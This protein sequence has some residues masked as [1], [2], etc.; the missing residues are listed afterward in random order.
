LSPQFPSRSEINDAPVPYQNLGHEFWA[1]AQGFALCFFRFTRSVLPQAGQYLCGL[2]QARRAT[3]LQMADVVP[4]SDSQALHHFLS[5]SDWDS[6]RVMDQV[7]TGVDAELG[8]TLDSCLVIDESSFPKK[9]NKSVGVARQWCGT[10]GK[11]DSCQVG[12]FASLGHGNRA[13]LIDAR[14]YLP[15]E[16]T[17]SPNRCRKAG[18]P[19]SARTFQTKPELALEMVHRARAQGLR[20]RWVAA[21]GGYG[22]NPAF[23][24]ALDDAGEVFVIDIHRD[25]RI[26]A[27]DPKPEIPTSSPG[28]SRRRVTEKKPMRVDAWLAQQ[29]ES[30]WQREWIRHTTKGELHL[31]VMRDMVWLWNGREASARCWHLLVTRDPNDPESLKYS[32]SN[33]SAETPAGRLAQIQ[34]QRYWIERAFQDAKREAGMA[35]YQARSWKAWHHHMALVMMALLFLLQQRKKHQST[36][37]LLSCTD[38]KILLAKVLPRRDVGLDEVLRLMEQRHK[39]RQAATKSAYQKRR[40]RDGPFL[41]VGNLTK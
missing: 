41:G 37:P 8:G 25:Q 29:P 17:N 13:S 40:T 11:T 28:R 22:N 15:R 1:F 24:Q 38:L 32:L 2:M 27:E 4:D 30:A 23:L 34:R 35:D 6:Q 18:V 14:L 20:F 3:M 7:A 10:R 19:E 21:D 12:V 9:G 31:D 26:Y 33:A 39:R 36:H 5:V 16:W